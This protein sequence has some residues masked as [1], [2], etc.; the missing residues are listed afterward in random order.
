[1]VL[2]VRICAFAGFLIAGFAAAQPAPSSEQFQQTV[3][4]RTSGLQM[5]S[6]SGIRQDAT[7]YLWLTGGLN[8]VVRF[9]GLAFTHLAIGRDIPFPISN[10]QHSLA[11]PDGPGAWFATDS[12]LV[13][14]D[15]VRWRLFTEADGVPQ[16]VNCLLPMP[17]GEL[18]VGSAFGQIAAVR[19]GRGRPAPVQALL[20]PGQTIYRMARESNGTVW[21]AASGGLWRY[22]DGRVQAFRTSEGLPAEPVTG[23]LVDRHGR[24]WA[25]MPGPALARLD[26]GSLRFL[27]INLGAPGRERLRVSGLLEDSRGDVWLAARRA[28]LFRIR[29]DA[30]QR[31]D[32]EGPAS[33]GDTFSVFED[34]ERSLWVGQVNGGALVQLRP[35]KVLQLAEGEPIVSV[36]E[37]HDGTLWFASMRSGLHSL[38]NGRLRRIGPED[39]LPDVRASMVSPAPGGGVWLGLFDAQVGLYRHGRWQLVSHGP[40]GSYLHGVV[41]ESNGRTWLFR[42][43][44]PP[45]I[46]ENGVA[47]PA[48]VA[49]P[50]AAI[51]SA[52]Q[53]RD[54]AL[55]L[56]LMSG[57]VYRWKDGRL[58]PVLAGVRALHLREDPGGGV[59]ISTNGVGLLYWNAG[60]VQR[61]NGRG[62]LPDL[63]VHASL[64]RDGEIWLLSSSGLLRIDKQALLSASPA[65]PVKFE[66][67]DRTDGLPAEESVSNG[68]AWARR[69]GTLVFATEAGLAM[70]PRATWSRNS[71]AP[72]VTVEAVRMDGQPTPIRS[73]AVAGGPRLDQLEIQYTGLSLAVAGKTMFRYRLRGLDQDWVE[74][75]TRRTA[76][77][78]KLPP[79]DYAFELQSSNNDG[80]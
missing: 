16:Q 51:E 40:P 74:A 75:G 11:D 29:A 17:G 61:W 23:V 78:T 3:W 18:W 59:W 24:V 57:G 69:D 20:P 50:S 70:V 35:R 43:M 26:P 31:V 34:R 5:N 64:E 41:N 76:F 15:G 62:G 7:G 45:E 77:Y 1:M 4:N 65:G 22:R 79:G 66:R 33:S 2:M 38:Q 12:G 27:P 73:R 46:V 53:T 13:H 9:D 54:G 49:W 8:P 52:I 39:G 6:I 21:V 19:Q 63:T 30:A 60:K 55:W 48:Q 32:L 68:P 25:S 80:V 67:L 42:T 10:V 14:S 44:G 72:A 58:E 71:V 36:A 47:R 56:G 28:G 37:D